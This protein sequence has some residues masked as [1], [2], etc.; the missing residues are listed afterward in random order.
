MSTYTAVIRQA[1]KYWVGW[2]Q[3]IPG[4]IAQADSRDELIENLQITLKDMIDMY[5]EQSLEGME[6]PYEKISITA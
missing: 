5:R 3:E 6:E 1:D 4:V 2:V